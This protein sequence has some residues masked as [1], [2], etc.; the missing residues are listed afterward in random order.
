[1]TKERKQKRLRRLRSHFSLPPIMIL[2]E[3]N[4][5]DDTTTNVE[6]GGG[7]KCKDFICK[8]IHILSTFCYFCAPPILMMEIYNLKSAPILGF[9]LF[10]FKIFVLDLFLFN[11]GKIRDWPKTVSANDSVNNYANDAAY[12]TCINIITANYFECIV[13]DF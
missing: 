5:I 3:A 12:F 2:T 6:G 9:G 8:F 11:M 13:H 7:S 1:M 10:L 4:C